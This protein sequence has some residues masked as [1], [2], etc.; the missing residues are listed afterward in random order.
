MTRT[1]RRADRHDV[2][3]RRRAFV[4]VTLLGLL[5]APPVVAQRP[6]AGDRPLGLGASPIGDKVKVRVGD[7]ERFRVE[8]LG[9]EVQHRW[10]LDGRTVGSASQWSFAPAASDVGLHR[11]AVTVTAREG[12][13]ARVWSVRV[14]PPHPPRIVDPS[15]REET[16]EAPARTWLHFRVR[17]VTSAELEQVTVTWTVDGEPAG[18]GDTLRWRP[19]QPGSFR[20]RA[21]V[22]SSLGSAVAR[23]WRIEATV[24]PTTTTSI[25]AETTTTSTTSTTEAPATTTTSTTEPEPITTTTERATT[26]TSSTTTTSERETTTTT[27]TPPTTTTRPAPATTTTTAARAAAGADDAAVQALLDRYA[28]A[29]SR[30]DVDALRA[31]GQVTNDRQA[32]ALR[33]YFAKTGPLESQ[34]ELLGI[35]RSDGRITVR[36]R[37]RDR[38]RNPAGGVVDEAS[39]PLEKTVVEG[40]G[41]LRFGGAR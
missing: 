28:A 5:S 26:T 3:A 34:V 19:P 15:P 18:Q 25:A 6:D 32:E 16:I 35:E 29:W 37:R 23:E 1:R 20:V 7:V 40:P 8:A 10:T 9:T 24:P 38:F 36:F 13:V 31:L 2:P 41:G 4:I 39:P 12:T 14:L 22:A 21:L 33:A 11:V 27:S 30:G 17:A